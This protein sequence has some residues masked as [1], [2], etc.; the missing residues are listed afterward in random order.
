MLTRNRETK[1][2]WIETDE[3]GNYKSVVNGVSEGRLI[4]GGGKGGRRREKER[5]SKIE[6]DRVGS[7]RWE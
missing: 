7:R 1:V 4:T 3:S 6:N 5:R 2:K